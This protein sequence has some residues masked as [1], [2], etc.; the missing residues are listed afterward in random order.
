MSVDRDPATELVAA[1]ADLWPAADV[2]G[3]AVQARFCVVPTAGGVGTALPLDSP[4]ASARA[5]RRFN[6][7]ATT[8]AVAK[9]LILAAALRV[10][11]GRMLPASFAVTGADTDSLATLLGTVFGEPVTFSVAIGT[12]RVNRK[13]VLEIFGADGRTLGFAKL[14]GTAVSDADVAAEA[15]ALPQLAE[16]SLPGLSLPRVLWSGS[17]QDARMVVISAVPQSPRQRRH[18]RRDPPLPE[19]AALTDTF[20]EGP[21]TIVE[22][23]WWKRTAETFDSLADPGRR[24]RA[25]ACLARLGERAGAPVP[26]SAWHGDWTPWN[27]ARHPNG[28][29]LWD[30]ER[31]DT[32]V[33]AG[34]DVL[35]Y[36]LNARLSGGL[37]PDRALGVLRDGESYWRALGERVAGDPEVGIGMYLA[38]I[39]ARYLPLCEGAGGD[40]LLPRTDALLTTFEL[41]AELPSL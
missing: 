5:V 2:A 24:G 21:A 28:L 20:A 12:A 6:A 9:R 1:V 30:W 10:G 8:P 18:D 41:W 35:H 16:H 3:G 31:F 27:M 38:E 23:D 37:E 29:S 33:P 14:G 19:I 39:L 7:A 26:F 17:W 36:L 22:S 15:A 25:S 32:G 11:V 40:I 13:R 4:R 34:L